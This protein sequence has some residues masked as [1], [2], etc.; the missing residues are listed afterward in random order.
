MFQLL[1]ST[2]NKFCITTYKQHAAELS[3]T[4]KEIQSNTR[5]VQRVYLSLIDEDDSLQDTAIDGLTHSQLVLE[6]RNMIESLKQQ[7]CI[8]VGRV[9]EY[10][11][12]VIVINPF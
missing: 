7:V 9:F 11:Y 5:E 10:N 2:V 1:N 6:S 8:S 3:A 12:Y 4:Q